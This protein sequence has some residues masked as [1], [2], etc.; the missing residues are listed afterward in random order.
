MTAALTINIVLAAL[1]LTAIVGMLVWSIASQNG[2]AATPIVRVARRRRST[3]AR[4]RLLGRTGPIE[5][6]A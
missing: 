4:A 2:D 6:Q 5:H 3:P 1:V